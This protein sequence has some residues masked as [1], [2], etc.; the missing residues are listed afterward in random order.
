VVSSTRARTARGR[1]VDSRREATGAE[2]GKQPGNEESRVTAGLLLACPGARS[3]SFD[4]VPVRQ[5]DYPDLE[6]VTVTRD[7]LNDP[8]KFVGG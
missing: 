8:R 4:A 3:Y 6:H 7:F 2:L 5:V 1:R